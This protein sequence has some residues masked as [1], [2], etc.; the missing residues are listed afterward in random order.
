MG[1]EPGRGAGRS[2]IDPAR[3][4]SANTDGIVVNDEIRN[5][6]RRCSGAYSKKH[7]EYPYL[8]TL[9]KDQP[10][11][12]RKSQPTTNLNKKPMALFPHFVKDSNRFSWFLAEF[13]PSGYRPDVANQPALQPLFNTACSADQPL[14]FSL[15]VENFLG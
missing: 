1:R 3:N 10:R 5:F 4:L 9:E 2:M 7:P 8:L 12:A 11:N 6:L 15:Q 14:I 13:D